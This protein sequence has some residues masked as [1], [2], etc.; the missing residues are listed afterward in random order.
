MIGWIIEGFGEFI[1]GSI[2]EETLGRRQDKRHARRLQRDYLAGRTIHFPGT[3]EGQVSWA[4]PANTPV[5]LAITS[6]TMS[7]T[8]D[9]GLGPGLRHPIPVD[10]LALVS[11]TPPPPEPAA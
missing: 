4:S 2:L 1:L 10:Q 6:E 3:V 8:A 7:W 11:C 5:W 9:P